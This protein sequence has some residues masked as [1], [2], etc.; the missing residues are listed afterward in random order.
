MVA[1]TEGVSI[2]SGVSSCQMTGAGN[3]H[4]FGR[5]D[6]IGEL[7]QSHFCGVG[8]TYTGLEWVQKRKGVERWDTAI[9]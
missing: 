6:V 2:P 1:Q 7:D 9:F 8:R 5:I 3:G 4:G